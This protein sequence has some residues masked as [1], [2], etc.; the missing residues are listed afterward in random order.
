LRSDFRNDTT[1]A[2]RRLSSWILKRQANSSPLRR[3]RYRANRTQAVV[4]IP[5]P[6]RGRIASVC[7]SETIHRLVE[8]LPNDEVVLY[9]D[10]VDIH[11]NPKIGRNY[12]LR[13]TQKT[14]LT[15]GKNAKRYLAGALCARTGRVVL[16]FLPPHCL[17]HYRIER[18]W[19]DLHANVTRNHRCRSIDELMREVRAELR[20]RNKRQKRRHAVAA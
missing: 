3:E 18:V 4:A 9:V 5:G 11:L 2:V 1:S 13:G 7:P 17:D 19:R 16:H 10:E 20:Q 6:L 15:P 12:M 14:V 8:R